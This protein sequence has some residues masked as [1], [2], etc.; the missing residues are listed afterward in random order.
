MGI[1]QLTVSQYIIYQTK[2]WFNLREI[3]TDFPTHTM[4]GLLK[5]YYLVQFAFWL[6]QIFVVNIEDKRKDYWQMFTHHIFT[7]ALMFTSY[8]YYQTKV[9]VVILAI[10]DVVDLLLPVSASFCKPK[11]CNN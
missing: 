5:W 7:S 3:W 4:N 8:G 9:G 11:P 2:Y 1:S 10:M 6:Q